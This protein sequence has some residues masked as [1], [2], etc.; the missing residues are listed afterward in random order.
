[1]PSDLLLAG[2]QQAVGEAVL[3]HGGARGYRH[4]PQRLGGDHGVPVVT[5]QALDVLL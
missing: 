4:P 3:P 2:V 1:V 5:E